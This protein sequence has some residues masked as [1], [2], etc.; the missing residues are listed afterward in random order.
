MSSEAANW[1]K[2][3]AVVPPG[4]PLHTLRELADFADP[5]G[6]FWASIGALAGIMR[7]SERQVIRDM[8][9]LRKAG[10][11]AP[12][13]DFHKTKSGQKVPFYQL[14]MTDADLTPRGDVDVTPSAQR[15]DT[16][17]TPRGDISGASRG[18][19]D[20]TQSKP[21]EPGCS[22]EHPSAGAREAFEKVGAAWIVADRDRFARPRA[23][24]AWNAAI[25]DVEPDD[26]AKAALRF[27]A[28]S[29]QVKRRRVPMLHK[30][31]ADELFLGWMGDAPAAANPERTRFAGPDEVR[32]AVATAK[33]EAFAV[34]YLDTA[35]WRDAERVIVAHTR[36]A[37]EK[38]TREAS[39][40]LRAI[41][42]TVAMPE[43][44]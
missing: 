29:D 23:L 11:I 37:F 6:V 12:T 28:E 31:L 35:T 32:A 4:A 39:H 14:A 2:W 5:E 40:V 7:K 22:T 19:V 43:L 41:K 38:L 8:G 42:V 26:L 3:R 16:G 1:V 20:V 21:L 15:G 10:L 34:S 25:V 24:E 33:G 27:L 36:T 18:D 17:V 13:G 44:V 30:W 9:R